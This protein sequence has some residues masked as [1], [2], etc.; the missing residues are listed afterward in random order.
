MTKTEVLRPYSAKPEL[1]LTLARLLDQSS[2]AEGRGIPTHSAFL[3]PEERAEA[4]RLLARLSPQKHLFSGGFSAAERQLCAFLPDWMDEE[5]W[6]CDEDCPVCA[7]SITVPPMAELSHRDYLGS[8]MA[9]GISREKFGDI[10]QT[11]DGAQL[12]LLR[13][14]LPMVESQWEKVGRYPLTLCRLSLDE[15]SPKE[16]M[17]KAVR[18]TVSSL[19][20]DSVVASGFSL[21]RARAAEL[22]EQGRVLRNHYPCEKPDQA[23]LEG[24]VF[25]CRGMGKFVLQRAEGKSKKG[26]ILLEIERYV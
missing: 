4:E 19:R 11:D 24:D 9:L 2:V 25:S 16:A 15:I 22:I 21:S 17:R 26:R 23:V 20:L 14:L 6:I 10:L 18:D 13:E 5:D 3:T 12:I 1:R 7:L 8:L